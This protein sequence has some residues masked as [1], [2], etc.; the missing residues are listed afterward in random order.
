MS[1][2]GRRT[3]NL[4]LADPSRIERKVERAFNVEHQKD[5]IENFIF[6]KVPIHFGGMSDPFST[7]EITLRSLKILQILDQIDYPVIISTKN[8]NV[9]FDEKIYMQIL[10][11]KNVVIQGIFFLHSTGPMPSTS[12]TAASR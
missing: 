9:F 11:M 7:P 6:T 10:M 5:V 1:R 12:A 8:T 2:G 4:L 3:S